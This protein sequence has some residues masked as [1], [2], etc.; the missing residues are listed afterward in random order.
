MALLITE[1]K[2]SRASETELA[3]IMSEVEAMADIE[4]Q[5]QLARTDDE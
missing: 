2:A 3:Q 5:E 4:A 1:N